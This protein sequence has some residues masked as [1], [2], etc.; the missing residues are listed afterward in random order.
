MGERLGFSRPILDTEW[1]DAPTRRS[2]VWVEVL[3]IVWLCWLYDE[4]SNLSPLR[5]HTALAHGAT[6]LRIERVWHLNPELTLNSWAAAHRSIALP[7]ANFY[8]SAHFVV[9]L[10]VVA[11]LWWRHPGLYRSLRNSLVL[12]NVI[13]FVVFWAY[14]LAPPRML[15][16]AG[17]VDVV[18]VT[19][20]WGSW[21]TNAVASQANELAAMPSLH[22][23]WACWTAVALWQMLRGR[24]WRVVV[25]VYPLLDGPRRD[26]DGEPF[27]ARRHRGHGHGVGGV[28]IGRASERGR[29]PEDAG[30]VADAEGPVAHAPVVV[31]GPQS[32][33]AYEDHRLVAPPRSTELNLTTAA[34]ARSWV[35]W[36]TP[37]YSA[38]RFWPLNWQCDPDDY[39]LTA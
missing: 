26:G 4:I 14:P 18:A 7:M 19:H 21:Q 30:P 37:Q 27:P 33:P 32:P 39:P 29:Q 11:V 20:A 3:V 35:V 31:A 12:I 28:R 5:L 16:A 1:T 38:V 22:M 34:S 23:A 17:F 25:V 13:G 24:R 36:S 15:P 10:G 2:R 9:T 8:D 6:L